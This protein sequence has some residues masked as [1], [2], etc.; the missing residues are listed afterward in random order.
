MLARH[1]L[2]AVAPYLY[3]T[4]ISKDVFQTL[5]LAGTDS[6]SYGFLTGKSN[7]LFPDFN[8][9]A[10]L[11]SEFCPGKHFEPVGPHFGG[12]VEAAHEPAHTSCVELVR[13]PLSA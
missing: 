1:V 5:Y 11:S 7:A 3:N 4:C 2:L 13:I 8:F 12:M 10:N 6:V 9:Y